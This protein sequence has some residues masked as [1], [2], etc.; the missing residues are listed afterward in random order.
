MTTSMTQPFFQA[1]NAHA[2]SCGEPPAWCSETAAPDEHRSYFENA[3]GEQWIASATKNLLRIAGGDASWRTIEV[4]NPDYLRIAKQAGTG[5]AMS[6]FPG[7]GPVTEKG[8]CTLNTEESLWL[9]AVCAAMDNQVAREIHSTL[10]TLP[11][12]PPDDPDVIGHGKL[13]K[14]LRPKGGSRR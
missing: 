9:I 12:L 13:L 7:V 3:H 14:S 10:L 4:A 6:F 11:L 8:G 1:T 2:E 5:I